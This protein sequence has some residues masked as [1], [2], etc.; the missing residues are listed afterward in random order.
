MYRIRKHHTMIKH[1]MTDWAAVSPNTHTHAQVS[2]HVAVD[3]PQTSWLGNPVFQAEVV[4]RS[5][6][7][8]AFQVRGGRKVGMER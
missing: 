2:Q 5:A 1:V 6:Q 8:R 3:I 7:W 4:V